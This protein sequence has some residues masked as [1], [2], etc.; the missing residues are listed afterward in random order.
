MMG[1]RVLQASEEVRWRGER[2]SICAEKL[3]AR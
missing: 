1:Q 3:C 2:A